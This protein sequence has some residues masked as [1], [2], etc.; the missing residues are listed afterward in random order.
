[1]DMTCLGPIGLLIMAVAAVI[2][3]LAS[4]FRGGGIKRSSEEFR[5]MARGNENTLLV[6]A[7]EGIVGKMVSQ[8]YPIRDHMN[9]H[10][11]PLGKPGH[12]LMHLKKPRNGICFDMPEIPAHPAMGPKMIKF[13]LPED[14][15]TRLTFTQPYIRENRR[16]VA[17]NIELERQKKEALEALYMG[18]DLPHV[19]DIIE[20]IYNVTRPVPKA[21]TMVTQ[22][23]ESK[24]EE[25]PK[26]GI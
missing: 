24:K 5:N 6:D 17:R 25:E 4:E 26:G 22:M 11:V 18:A 21:P 10:W 3:Y 19:I 7:E 16:L 23:Q 8:P 20:Q 15:N 1:M 14:P 9:V 13:L 12:G 2:I